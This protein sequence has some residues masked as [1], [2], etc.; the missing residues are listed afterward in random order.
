MHKSGSILVNSPLLQSTEEARHSAHLRE[1]SHCCNQQ[2][3]KSICTTT[4]GRHSLTYQPFPSFT[5]ASSQTSILNSPISF[6][7]SL[8]F[9]PQLTD[10]TKSTPLLSAPGKILLSSSGGGTCSSLE[11]RSVIL[12]RSSTLTRLFGFLAWSKESC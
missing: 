3:P 12:L 5:K 7:L 2:A 1:L 11:A 9:R 10:I 4:W 8:S 6:S